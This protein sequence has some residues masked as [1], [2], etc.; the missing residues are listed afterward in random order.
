MFEARV[1][2]VDR[3]PGRSRSFHPK[4]FRFEAQNFGIAFVGSSNLSLSALDTGVEWNLRVDRDR[5]ADA[6]RRVV[7]A[8]ESLWSAAPS[9]DLEWIAAYAR[10]ATSARRGPPEGEVEAEPLETVPDPHEVQL[11]ALAALRDSREKGRRR[12]LAVIAT[13]LGKTWLA[14]FDYGQLR[15][16]LGGVPPRLLFVAHRRELLRQAATT[17]SL[18]Q[19]IGIRVT[20]RMPFECTQTQGVRKHSS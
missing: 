19:N 4:A 7:E 9:L 11:E 20:P 5:D 6:Y 16:E 17:Y 2:E 1:V 15:E 18:V 8:F 14:A 12:A 13:G 3:L 10:R